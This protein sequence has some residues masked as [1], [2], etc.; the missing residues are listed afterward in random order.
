MK[1]EM[2]SRTADFP[3]TPFA[4]MVCVSVVYTDQDEVQ[5]KWTQH[6]RVLYKSK[7]NSKQHSFDK[8]Q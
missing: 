1:F 3:D 7:D 5:D 2:P 4:N 8:R 6:S